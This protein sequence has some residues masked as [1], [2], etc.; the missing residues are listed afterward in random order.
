MFCP[1]CNAEYR[2]GFTMCSDCHVALVPERQPDLP[3]QPDPADAIVNLHSPSNEMELAMIRSILDAEEIYY[4]VNNDNFGSLKVGPRIEIFNK[5]MIVVPYD[6]YE[7]ASELI[8][9][10]LNKISEQED[11]PKRA[12][13]L[14][15]KIRMGVE[16]LLFGWIMPGRKNKSNKQEN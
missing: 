1:N 11:E 2:S 13:S 6:Q 12:Y 16:I 9:D 3:N 8:T 5:K 15:D 14:S 7:R 4:F 10:Y